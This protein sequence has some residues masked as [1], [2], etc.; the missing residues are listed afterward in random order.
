MVHIFQESSKNGTSLTNGNGPISDEEDTQ[1][2][3]KV[4]SNG[5]SDDKQA[6]NTRQFQRFYRNIFDILVERVHDVSSY[7]RSACLKTWIQ[8]VEKECI[9]VELWSHITEVAV[10]RLADKTTIVRKNATIL[11]TKLVDFNP[12]N[13]NLNLEYHL[14]R[15]RMLHVVIEGKKNQIR[16]QLY[17]ACAVTVIQQDTAPVKQE[18]VETE[19]GMLALDNSNDVKVEVNEDIL[20]DMAGV[21]CAAINNTEIDFSSDSEIINLSKELQK[22]RFCVQFVQLIQGTFPSLR[23][24]L[25]SKCS[26]DISEALTF[27]SCA[28]HF[29]INQSAVCLQRYFI[30]YYSLCMHMLCYMLIY[31]YTL[32]YCIVL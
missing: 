23:K 1:D 17:P 19:D 14:E 32:L 10:D 26:T 25:T 20:E 28:L 9:S 12:F 11:L 6:F 15:E 2:E 21:A 4:D 29:S 24:M 27:F 13:G 30:V 22:C 31:I 7:T 18:K 5:D 8:L 3:M 16:E